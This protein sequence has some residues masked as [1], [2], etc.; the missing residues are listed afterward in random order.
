MDKK[1]IFCRRYY[2]SIHTL[3]YYKKYLTKKNLKTI[4]FTEKIKNKIV[5]LPLHSEMKKNDIKYL[6]NN[7][8]KFFKN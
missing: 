3:T 5:A 4:P 1:K 8:E 2:K 7:I 6:F